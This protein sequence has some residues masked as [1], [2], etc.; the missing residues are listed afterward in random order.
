MRIAI[1]ILLALAIPLAAFADSG[2]KAQYTLSYDMPELEAQDA[3]QGMDLSS[4]I[5]DTMSGD[6]IW[7]EGNLRMD[8]P[9]PSMMM[10]GPGSSS[11]TVFDF[12]D[13]VMYMLMPGQKQA[14]EFD[15]GGESTGM[16]DSGNPAEMYGNTANR[17]DAMRDA[18]NVKLEELGAATV[19]G[20]ACQHYRYSMDMQEEVGA[21]AGG[22]ADSAQVAAMA[23]N[24]SGEMWVSDVHEVPVKVITNT[25]GMTMT[26]QL[27]NIEEWS[28]DA[29]TFSVPEGYTIVT[30]AEMM[31]QMM[32]T[33]MQQQ[34]AGG[35]ST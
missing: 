4:M 1:T 11:V 34:G 25:M 32:G 3:P 23:G 31:Q 35:A 12:A 8:T 2:Y 26:W 7:T 24:V 33:M 18:E 5:P 29:S 6:I 17:I 27:A 10:G 21:Q 28:G 19:N 16:M 15:L 20:Y 9:M 13:E 22:N 30:M 14:I